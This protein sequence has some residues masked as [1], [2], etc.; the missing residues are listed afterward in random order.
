M[1]GLRALVRL[2]ALLLVGAILLGATDAD[3]RRRRRKHRR[4]RHSPGF[5]ANM[6]PYWQWPPSASMKAEGERCL[7]HLT[8]LG[9]EWERAKA[10]RKI[11]TPI[12]VPAMELGGV[13]LVHRYGGDGPFVMDCQLA[14][15]LQTHG[16]PALRE[17]G[18]TEIRF[19][20]IHRYGYLPRTRILSRH[21][22]GLGI[23][24]TEMVTEDGVV[25]VVKGDYQR[26]DEVLRRAEEKIRATGAFRRPLTPGNDPRGHGDH[27][28][29]EG[30]TAAERA[31]FQQTS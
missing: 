15:D 5:V 28:H 3:A 14:E 6:P 30:R 11:V 26:G 10:T 7:A 1:P 19:T 23:D 29:L 13:K 20:S 17:L 9:V 16:G 25:H 21:A 4:V 24:V 12:V 18:V 27:F 31:K 2:V 8:E 22:T